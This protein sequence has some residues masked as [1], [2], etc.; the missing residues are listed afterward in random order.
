MLLL[1]CVPLFSK[2]QI[3]IPKL[4][5]ST[6]SSAG[7]LTYKQANDIEFSKQYKNN[8][9]FDSYITKYDVKIQIGDT[10]TIG[11]AVIKRKSQKYKVG[12]IFEN[13]FIGNIGGRDMQ[14]YE[15]LPYDYSG[16]KV[17]IHSIY[18][19]HKMYTGYNPFK[20]RKETPLFVCLFVKPIKDGSIISTI[21]TYPRMTIFNLEESL[22]SEEIVNSNPLLTKSEAIRILKE[23]KDL[24]ELDMLSEEEYL[25]LKSKLTPIIKNEK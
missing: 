8:T 17:I 16:N 11:N 23:S 7:E 14:N 15:H 2:S 18:V 4:F 21:L 25:K 22:E 19:N 6:S 5:I 3:K 20:N 24:M 10:L 9:K 12:D 13:I 1:I